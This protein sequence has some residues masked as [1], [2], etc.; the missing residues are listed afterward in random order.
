[1]HITFCINKPQRTQLFINSSVLGIFLDQ[2]L[3]ERKMVNSQ[4]FT[5]PRIKEFKILIGYQKT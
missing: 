3:M 5:N 2:F 1:M 4:M